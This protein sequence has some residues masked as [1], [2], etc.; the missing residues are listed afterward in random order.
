MTD[1]AVLDDTQYA[2]IAF[3]LM[4]RHNLAPHPENYALWFHYA[5][6]KNKDLLRE[7]DNI[8]NNGLTFTQE[9]SAYL[10]NKYVLAGR[11]QKA[12]DDAATQAQKVLLEV[13]KVINDFSGETQSYSKD[14]DQYLGHITEEFADTSVSL[15][16]G[17]KASIVA[18]CM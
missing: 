16:H 8:V 11:S 14:V 13:L 7:I 2:K 10:Y 5:A 1:Q 4:Q 15:V 18:S 17:F 12:V 3:S 9:T 6:G